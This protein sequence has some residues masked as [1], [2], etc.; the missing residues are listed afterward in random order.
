M[1]LLESE[2]VVSKCF[3][4]EQFRN[5]ALEKHAHVKGKSGEVLKGARRIRVNKNLGGLH[6]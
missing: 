5:A 6:G 1:R 2:V 4:P 3:Y